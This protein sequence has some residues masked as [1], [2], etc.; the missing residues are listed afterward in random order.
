MH[1]VSVQF[2]QGVESGTR[3]ALVEER[4]QRPQVCQVRPA[5][6]LRAAALQREVLGVLL[7]NRL[8][9]AR[10]NHTSTVADTHDGAGQP[11][12]RVGS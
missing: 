4:D 6:V 11:Q 2:T 8:T 12:G 9:T 7:Q 1:H 3:S 10:I 5:G